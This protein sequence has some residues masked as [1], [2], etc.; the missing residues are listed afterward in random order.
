MTAKKAKPKFF[1]N[2]AQDIA[3]VET[4]NKEFN[5]IFNKVCKYIG[6]K[7]TTDSFNLQQTAMQFLGSVKFKG[8]YPY[9]T[10][11][12]IKKGESV[13]INTDSHEKPGMHW[14]ALYRN[15]QKGYYF[16]D[17][18]GRE[19]EH[20]IPDLKIRVLGTNCDIASTQTVRQFGIQSCCGQM[21][22]SF[23]IYL[24]AQPKPAMALVI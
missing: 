17:S 23:L 16:F 8:V 13:I 14:T 22:L 6:K 10:M 2:R 3:Y 1:N 11:P 21:S 24:Y 19:W 15:S 20:V 4:E 18:Y 9:D 12:K 5:D 7:T